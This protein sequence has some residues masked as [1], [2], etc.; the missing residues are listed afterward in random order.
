MAWTPGETEPAAAA[1]DSTTADPLGVSLFTAVQE[2]TG[3]QNWNRK[4][5][6]SKLLVIDS[7]EKKPSEN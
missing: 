5:V 1:G 2:Q 6:R 4:K 7:V 3:A